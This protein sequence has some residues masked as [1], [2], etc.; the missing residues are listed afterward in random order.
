MG[1]PLFSVQA[2]TSTQ[3]LSW[4]LIRK[5]HQD[6]ENNLQLSLVT[7]PSLLLNHLNLGKSSTNGQSPALLCHLVDSN[8]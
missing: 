5:F 1:V 2:L 6:N 8:A 7:A 3:T 4:L